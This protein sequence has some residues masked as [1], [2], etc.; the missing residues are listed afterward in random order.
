MAPSSWLN[1]VMRVSV[2][3]IPTWQ[4]PQGL[5]RG[6][7]V[8]KVTVASHKERV[9]ACVLLLW[10]TSTVCG[11][12]CEVF[13]VDDI[14]A[15]WCY[16]TWRCGQLHVTCAWCRAGL[17]IIHICAHFFISVHTRAVTEKHRLRRQIGHG[18]PKEEERSHKAQGPATTHKDRT[19]MM[20]APSNLMGYRRRWVR[21]E[22]EESG[23]DAE[24]GGT[25]RC[26]D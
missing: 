2:C 15:E 26:A 8:S 19:Q 12:A 13:G 23:G 7:A 6:R 10:V 4:L 20:M 9:K 18:P 3:H 22:E 16:V 1:S 21:V 5:G 11:P 24:R 17:H 25:V 14:S